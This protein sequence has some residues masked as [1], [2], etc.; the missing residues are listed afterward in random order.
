[1]SNQQVRQEAAVN[2]LDSSL[3]TAQAQA[4]QLI[5]MMEFKDPMVGNLV[6]VKA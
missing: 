5:Q 3:D 6:D 4:D 1:M 2:I